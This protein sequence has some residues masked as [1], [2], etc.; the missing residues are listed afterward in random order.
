LGVELPELNRLAQLLPLQLLPQLQVLPNH[1]IPIPDSTLQLR[2][3]GVQLGKQCLDD[4][5]LATDNFLQECGVGGGG[6][7]VLLELLYQL[8]H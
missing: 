3:P 4:F 1:H 8:I 7:S 2:L 5:I 6:G